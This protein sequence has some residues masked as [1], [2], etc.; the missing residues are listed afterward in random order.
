MFSLSRGAADIKSSASWWQTTFKI[1]GQRFALHRHEI[2][3][4]DEISF[5]FRPVDDRG[6]ITTLE[7]DT[8]SAG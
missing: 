8:G 2:L 3:E 4:I 7:M 5:Q 6:L 1:C